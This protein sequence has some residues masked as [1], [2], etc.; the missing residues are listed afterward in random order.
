MP[1]LDWGTGMGADNEEAGPA[2]VEP[3][4][5][6]YAGKGLGCHL[7]D[8]SLWGPQ[9]LRGHHTLEDKPMA[10]DLT[11]VRWRGRMASGKRPRLRSRAELFI[12]IF[13]FF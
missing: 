13:Y 4:C 5:G 12:F 11:P 2:G 1:R 7:E 10:R 6:R 8:S 9:V 3:E